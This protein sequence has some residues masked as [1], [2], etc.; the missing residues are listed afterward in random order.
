MLPGTFF[1]RYAGVFVI[2]L[3]ASVFFT[4]VALDLLRSY[5]NT[6]SRRS[7]FV[8]TTVELKSGRFDYN[9]RMGGPDILLLRHNILRWFS[10]PL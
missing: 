7:S 2:N 10:S 8:R 4:S 1:F 5:P 3:T 9:V 6:G